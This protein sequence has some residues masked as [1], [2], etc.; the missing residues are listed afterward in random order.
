MSLSD[1]AFMEEMCEEEEE[2]KMGKI[3]KKKHGVLAVGRRV[4][5]GGSNPIAAAL[6]LPWIT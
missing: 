3:E 4:E 1:N 6:K 5:E 2:Q